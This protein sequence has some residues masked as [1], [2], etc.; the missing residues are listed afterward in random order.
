MGSTK[1]GSLFFTLP[2]RAPQRAAVVARNR[3]FE[4]SLLEEAVSSELVS[5][6]GFPAKLGKYREVEQFWLAL[7]AKVTG[8]G[9]KF[10]MLMGKF[11]THPN[12]EF[13]SLNRGLNWPN[14]QLSTLIRQSRLPNN[15]Q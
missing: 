7:A 12:R 8:L 2:T 9:S 1:L 4:D 10:S 3:K 6:R 5:A 13:Y 15:P 14:R 11:P